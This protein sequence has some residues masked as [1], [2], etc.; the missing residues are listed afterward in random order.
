MP[1]SELFV[2]GSQVKLS[3][4]M[5]SWGEQIMSQLLKSH[6]AIGKIVGEMNFSKVDPVKGN[7]VGYVTLIGRT[8]RIPFIVDEYELNPLDIYIDNMRYLPLTDKAVERLTSRNWPFRLISQKERSEILKTASLCER[9]RSLKFVN[10]N[11][12]LLDKI[13][14]E[15]PDVY[16]F[17]FN[18]KVEKEPEPFVARCFVKTAAHEKPIVVRDLVGKDVDYTLSEFSQKYGKDFVKQLMSN[19]EVIVSN[20]PHT[21]RLAIDKL[22]VKNAYKPTHVREGYYF[23]NNEP[24]HAYRYDHYRI[25]D[26]QKSSSS[27]NVFITQCG[28]YFAFGSLS[29]SRHKHAEVGQTHHTESPG[30]G[31]YA[32][33]VVGDNV[34]GPMFITSITKIGSEKIYG[35][36]DDQLNQSRMRTSPDVKTIVKLD[37]GSYLV[38]HYVKILKIHPMQSDESPA[39]MLIKSAEAQVTVSRQTNGKFTINDGGLSGIEMTKLNNL[40]RGDATMVLM[41]TGLSQ[42]DAKYALMKS[43]ESG[44]YSYPGG[45]SKRASS[46]APDSTLSQRAGEIVDL[47]HQGHILKVASISG[48]KS[49]I[50]L[51][52]GLNMIN[53]NNIKRFKLIVPEIY[54]MLD[55]LCKLLVLKRMNRSL[56]PD[57]NESELVG[58]IH[59]LDGIANSLNSL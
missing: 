45:M 14:E 28:K 1:L 33:V 36:N 23:Y 55:K 7:S 5:N 49:N 6:P 29:E 32:V 50:D 52:L 51:A 53:A 37:D 19:G 21:V 59:S 46:E 17:F 58:S 4:D 12:I 16:D 42:N 40:G 2:I 31:D 15:H 11:T 8:Q 13:A 43:L 9:D 41:R 57:I 54:S 34:Y 18:Q 22:E 48:D 20:L 3:P 24:F 47:A 38:S 27:P 10:D 44:S 35:F 30:I 25:S 26:L 56:F 39:A